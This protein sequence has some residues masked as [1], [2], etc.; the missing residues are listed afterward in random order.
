MGAKAKIALFDH[1]RVAALSGAGLE[2]A[3]PIEVRWLDEYRTA[4]EAPRDRVPM[5]R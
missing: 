5:S 1:P 4:L 3:R 2:R